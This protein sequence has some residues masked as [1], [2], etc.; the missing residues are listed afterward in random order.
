LEVDVFVTGKT[1]GVKSNAGS[2]R[3]LAWKRRAEWA[4]RLSSGHSA[5]V[6]MMEAADFWEREDLTLL[7]ELNPPGFWGI[8]LQA[9]VCPAA[10]II[11]EVSFKYPV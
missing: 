11:R 9:Q 4:W 2:N 3:I 6:A 1:P 7:W 5:F 8:L 10:V